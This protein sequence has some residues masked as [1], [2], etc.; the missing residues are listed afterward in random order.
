MNLN[1]IL[2]VTKWNLLIKEVSSGK[3]DITLQK[4]SSLTLN[5]KKVLTRIA[6]QEYT[7]AHKHTLC[8]FPSVI[9]P[10]LTYSQLLTEDCP[11]S[12]R[13][14]VP[15][16]ISE[17]VLTLIDAHLGAFTHNNDGVRAALADGPLARCQPRNLVADDVGTQSHH[18]GQGPAVKV[19]RNTPPHV[20]MSIRTQPSIKTQ[21]Y[22]HVSTHI[23]T[24]M[25]AWLHTQTHTN[26]ES[27]KTFR[28]W[29]DWLTY[30]RLSRTGFNSTSDWCTFHTEVKAVL[31][32]SIAI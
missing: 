6:T 29:S 23:H 14:T 18:R 28:G 11:L 26:T 13:R 32:E 31:H 2:V 27:V 25:H 1:S 20:H 24:C 5:L 4:T 9:E 17:L 30:M 19:K 21:T 22:A 7:Y 15:A 10:R 8:P 16:S 3:N 12:Q